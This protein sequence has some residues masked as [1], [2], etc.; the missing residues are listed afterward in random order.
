MD[1]E[2]YSR[3]NM[4]SRVAKNTF[5]LILGN[6]GNKILSFFLLLLLAR[7]LGDVNF[8]KLA[9]AQSF[10]Q[11]FIIL[12]DLGVGFYLIREIA[13]DKGSA[14]KSIGNALTLKIFLSFFVFALIAFSVG[15]LGYPNDTRVLVYFVS[16]YFIFVS[17]Y[18]LFASVFVAYERMEFNV[19]V[20]FLERVLLL[21]F[22]LTLFALHRGL[23]AVGG[24]YCLA[25][26][27][28]LMLATVFLKF[29]FHIGARPELDPRFLGIL[30]KKSFP[31]AL[32]G[33][34]TALYFYGNTV[35][36]SK[37]NGDQAAGWYGAGFYPAF[38]IQLISGAFLGAIYPLM[39]R[40]FK[41]SA[42]T[43][44]GVYQKSFELMLVFSFPISLG[45]YLTA[46]KLM[47]FF[48]GQGYLNSIPVF[49]IL[50]AGTV[51]FCL[52]S[53]AAHLLISID[54]QVATMRLAGFA[55]AVNIALALPLVKA[56][57]PVGA[58]FA[59]L[60]SGMATLV[61][62]FAY[63]YRKQYRLKL[64]LPLSRVLA[65]SL[66]MA[67]ALRYFKEI[68]VLLLILIAVFVYGSVIVLTGYF[69]R[70]DF[71]LLQKAFHNKGRDEHS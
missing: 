43:L 9:F 26:F 15:L 62:T 65:A 30:L 22:C 17:L 12:M 67:A 58:A 28:A 35:I 52:N 4:V 50:I 59:F 47:P 54:R 8:G 66:V 16:L 60:V 23:L 6:I 45:G 33:I 34:F 38:Y 42:D 21:A 49:K 63:L 40:L 10:V 70:G 3:Q 36:I 19:A 7:R 53:L 13:R 68:N 5:W 51:F 25:G 69:S 46:G 39:S 57:G 11:I 64:V 48:Y 20:S 44:K 1:S 56:Y 14:A 29:K 61:I 41:D 71:V 31:I 37:L 24:A 32:G 18:S 27:L 2:I 55:V